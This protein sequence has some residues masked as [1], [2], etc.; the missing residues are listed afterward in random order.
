[1]TLAE[2]Y[3]A[4]LRSASIAQKWVAHPLRLVCVRHPSH[5]PR[6]SVI[7]NAISPAM[8]EIWERGGSRVFTLDVLT[9]PKKARTQ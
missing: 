2:Q 9:P 5:A 8:I 1:M 6:V 3:D 7:G 4:Q